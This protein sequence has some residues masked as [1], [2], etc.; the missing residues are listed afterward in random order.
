MGTKT[1][2]LHGPTNYE[3]LSSVHQ[4][5]NAN[6]YRENSQVIKKKKKL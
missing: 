2:S 1:V 6:L 5:K 4:Q 3:N